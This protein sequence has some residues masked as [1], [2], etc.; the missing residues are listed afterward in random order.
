VA[1]LEHLQAAT[2]AGCAADYG[3]ERHITDSAVIAAD[4][5]TDRGDSRELERAVIISR[6][7]RGAI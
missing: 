7:Q 6:A 3:V 2:L 4:R 5:P 1:R